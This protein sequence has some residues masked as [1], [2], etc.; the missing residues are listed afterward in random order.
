[1]QP[2]LRRLQGGS[3][4]VLLFYISLHL[5]NHALAIWSLDLAERGLTLAMQLWHSAPGK[6]GIVPTGAKAAAPGRQ[7]KCAT[8]WSDF[9]R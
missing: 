6:E 7:R 4:L 8:G 1:M 9:A 3:G 2:I 5:F